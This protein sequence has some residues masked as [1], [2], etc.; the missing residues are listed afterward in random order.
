MSNHTK[1][2][3][4][5]VEVL[6]A[7]L[8]FGVLSAI[9]VPRFRMYKERSYVAAMKTDV[10]HIRL[11]EEEYFAEHQ[12]YST[13][14]TALDFRTTSNVR[15][16]LTSVDLIGGYTAVAFHLNLP[17]QECT[18]KVGREATNVPSGEIVCGPAGS[19]S[20]SGTVVP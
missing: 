2:G 12:R 4:T 15:L 18:T 8:V 13:D 17:G 3:F 14:T 9:A 20:G 1:R 16:R 6:V 7:L 5:F 10:G 11:A 19:G